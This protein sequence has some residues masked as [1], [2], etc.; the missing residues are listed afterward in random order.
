[1]EPTSC[2]ATSSCE[3]ELETFQFHLISC[4]RVRRSYPKWIYYF[5][6]VSNL[7]L[8]FTGVIAILPFP[9]NPFFHT[10]KYL[11]PLVVFFE[12]YRRSQWGV[13]RVEFQQVRALALLV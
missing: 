10:S 5:C 1:M 13:L 12:I 11:G 3:R 8:R 9:D 6:M 4:S 2:C 7:L